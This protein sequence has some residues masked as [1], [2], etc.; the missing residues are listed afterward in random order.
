MNKLIFIFTFFIAVNFTFA[1]ATKCERLFDSYLDDILPAH[2]SGEIQ[3]NMFHE[4][5]DIRVMADHIAKMKSSNRLGFVEKV[6]SVLFGKITIRPEI[7]FVKDLRMIVNSD[8][9][10]NQNFAHLLNEVV[11]KRKLIPLKDALDILGNNTRKGQMY[12]HYS[13]VD[14]AFTAFRDIPKEKVKLVDEILAGHKSLPKDVASE[15]RLAFLHSNLGIDELEYAVSKGLVL[16]RSSEKAQILIEYIHYLESV[17]HIDINKR[18]KFLGKIREGFDETYVGKKINPFNIRSAFD[19]I[20]KIYTENPSLLLKLRGKTEFFLSPAE[21]FVLS[22]QAGEVFE[23]N[24]FVKETK[25][26]IE[27]SIK[28]IDEDLAILRKI[29]A[30]G[31]DVPQQEMDKLLQRKEEI[32]QI[33]R[34]SQSEMDL[35]LAKRRLG[36]DVTQDQIDDVIRKRNEAILNKAQLRRAAIQAHDKG[37][38]FRQVNLNCLGG[39][40]PRIRK[41]S[42]NFMKFNIAF[43]VLFSVP[44]SYTINH[45]DDFEDSKYFI[46]NVGFDQFFSIVYSIVR[47]LVITNFSGGPVAKYVAYYTLPTLMDIPVNGFIYQELFQNKEYIREIQKLYKGEV[48]ESEVEAL[49]QKYKNDPEFRQKI[50]KLVEYLN[51]QFDKE[52]I[53]NSIYKS[54]LHEKLDEALKLDP[55]TLDEE[56]SRQLMLGLLSEKLYYESTGENPY[57]ITGNKGVDR[58]VFNAKHRTWRTVKDLFIG[59]WMYRAL[60]TQPF[61]PYGTWGAVIGISITNSILTNTYIYYKRNQELNF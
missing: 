15:Y 40:T 31:Q 20:D 59:E 34:T 54:P 21:R 53:R 50:E 22:R 10:Y 5:F 61:G 49:Y 29:K 43:G 55:S 2:T 44:A 47:T 36:Q 45:W 9:I 19:D 48:D 4:D 18:F 41:A 57:F 32:Q 37:K 17:R 6:K 33:V 8:F 13:P 38:L 24:D 3:W 23:R 1:Q 12:L 58:S 51:E 27:E 25:A 46:E 35:L 30:S 7:E 14:E 16:P 56:E 60:C 11:F 39:G 42:K 28:S 52:Q 26:M